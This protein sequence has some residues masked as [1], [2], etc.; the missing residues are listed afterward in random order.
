[1]IIP[2][3]R[4]DY[5]KLLEL[6][7][8]PEETHL[9][10]KAKLDLKDPESRLNSVKDGH[11]ISCHS[12]PI[13]GAIDQPRNMDDFAVADIPVEVPPWDHGCSILSGQM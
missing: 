9:D 10:L 1:M 7:G 8:N 12:E 5:E 2:D 6:L 13:D 4:T 11:I 3:A